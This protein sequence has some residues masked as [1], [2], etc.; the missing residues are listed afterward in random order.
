MVS[1]LVRIWR[2]RAGSASAS[3]RSAGHVELEPLGLL[4]DPRAHQRGDLADGVGHVGRP[5]VDLDAAGLDARDVEQVVD[6][7]DEPVGGQLDDL[8]ELALAVVEVGAG[9]GEQL[10][11]ALDRRQRAAQLVRGGGDE[12][13]LEPLEPDALGARRGRSRPCRVSPSSRAAVTSSVRPSRSSVCSPASASSSGGRKPSTLRA[14]LEVG[15]QQLGARVALRRPCRRRRRSA[16]A[17][18]RLRIVVSSRR[19]SASTRADAPSRSAA[20][21]LNALG[22]RAQLGGA[23]AR[24]DAGVELAGGEPARRGD[25]PVER[26]PHGADHRRDE[27]RARRAARAARRRRRPARRGASRCAAC[28]RASVEAAR[29]GARRATRSRRA[30]TAARR[31]GAGGRAA[32][33]GCGRRGHVAGARP[34]RRRRAGGRRR[35]SPRRRAGRRRAARRRGCRRPCAASPPRR[36]PPPG[37]GWP[38]PAAGRPRASS[39]S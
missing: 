4:V 6:Q 35:A 13:A 24:V 39:S 18:P 30:P 3:G 16:S 20:M 25:E 37:A 1:R 33:P 29:A 12:L 14:G 5:A 32:P 11:E 10:D 7:V 27:D 21:A 31:R 28:A 19:R 38:R 36:C 22:Q 15:H 9:G 23:V 2:T 26:A 8:D 17:S 34:G